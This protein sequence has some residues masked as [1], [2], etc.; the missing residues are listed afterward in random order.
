[1]KNREIYYSQLSRAMSS[2]THEFTSFRCKLDIILADDI[3]IELII[4]NEITQ[5]AFAIGRLIIVDLQLIFEISLF[6]NNSHIIYLKKKKKRP[7]K[8]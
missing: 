2:M 7:E 3:S 5:I 6:I 8:K 1:M 4:D